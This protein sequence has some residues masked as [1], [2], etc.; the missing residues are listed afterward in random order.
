M[1]NT[2]TKTEVDVEVDTRIE[3]I[4]QDPDKRVRYDFNDD[5]IVD[6]EEWEQVRRIVRAE[7]ET[8]RRRDGEEEATEA[9]SAEVAES[10]ELL[11]DRFELREEIGRGGQGKTHLAVD[12]Q[13]GQQVAVKELSIGQV[14]EWKTIELFERE[15]EA[16]E[17]LDHP[18][19]P[20]YI[21]S[22]HLD[23][24]EGPGQRFYLVQEYVEGKSLSALIEDGY[25]SNEEDARSF[26][27]A[28]LEIVNYMHSQSPPVIH[29]DIKPS[30]LIQRTN[31]KLALVDFG[32]AQL[33]MP[34][35][36]GGS[37]VV[38]TSGYMPLEQLMGRAVPATDL[39]AVGAT[40]VHLLSH[41]H[42]AD[43]PVVQMRLQFD[44]YVNV[45]DDFSR[46]LHKM[47][48]PHAEDRF[49]SA[50]E[51]VRALRAHDP[52]QQASQAAVDH[53]RQAPLQE[54]PD[55]GGGE[56]G[57]I[58]K[59]MSGLAESAM[60]M[61]QPDLDWAQPLY[62]GESLGK[63]AMTDVEK[64]V[65]GERVL[66][67]IPAS[68]YAKHQKIGGIIGTL[69]CSAIGIGML[70]GAAFSVGSGDFFTMLLFG[71]VWSAAGV[72]IGYFTGKSVTHT[73]LEMTPDTFRVDKQQLVGHAEETYPMS[74]VK[75]VDIGWER[76][77]K[78]KR[79]ITVFHVLVEVGFDTLEIG[80]YLE[81]ADLLWIATEI[82]DYAQEHGSLESA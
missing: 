46:F 76:K 41:R 36:S 80:Q 54:A 38:G 75:G 72:L 8:E 5:G 67:D 53:D 27:D 34:E 30:N 56:G 62:E 66:F 50:L 43:L 11:Q 71:V 14:V 58:M 74:S 10:G 31:G 37:T 28:L 12:Q 35:E 33:V 16:L 63:P 26:V 69:L 48:E 21:D 64:K 57:A 49:Q 61:G 73:E 79:R 1:N 32:A 82:R 22:F 29:R 25:R 47:L 77:K 18:A 9:A 68:S 13:S 6:D 59:A 17:S 3:K 55:R 51:A 2:Q 40:T 45:S 4:R 60:K 15:A 39:Y 65:E 81:N 44:D 7:V 52:T 20:S 19:I 70:V 23:L 42:P 78:N 24:D